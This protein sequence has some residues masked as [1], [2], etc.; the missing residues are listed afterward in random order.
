MSAPIKLLYGSATPITCTL[1][2]L[3]TGAAQQS[4]FVDNTTNLFIDMVIQLKIVY[5]NSAPTGNV[6]I[7]IAP[8]LD[9]TN[10]DGG[11]TGSDGSYS[12]A[13]LGSNLP[14][15]FNVLPIQNGTQYSTNS[16]TFNMGYVPPKFAVILTN[17]SGFTLSAGSSLQYVGI[18]A[19]VG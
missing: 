4:T 16:M 8:T 13:T 11:A 5:P 12:Y 15:I 17:N 10:Y 19:Q 9:G 3:A 1:S 7:Y 6:S 18:K 14:L 2:G